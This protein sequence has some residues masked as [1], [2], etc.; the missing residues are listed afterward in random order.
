MF[1]GKNEK[2]LSYVKNIPQYL[3][4]IA[5][6][7]FVAGVFYYTVAL[8][9]SFVNTDIFDTLI[10]AKASY[11]SG[12]IISP[13][14]SYSAFL[15]F[16]GSLIMLP[17]IP[18]FGVSFTTHVIGMVIFE[19][20]FF[21]CFVLFFKR[22]GF[23]AKWIMFALIADCSLWL[24][25]DKFREMFMEH[26]IYYSLSAL[27]ILAGY[28]LI[29]SLIKSFESENRKKSILLCVATFLFFMLV[30]TDGFQIVGLSTV[31]IIAAFICERFFDLKTKVFAKENR[32]VIAAVIIVAIATM[33]GIIVLKILLNGNVSE[34]ANNFSV[35]DTNDHIYMYPIKIKNY[36]DCWYQLFEVFFISGISIS[37]MAQIPV[38]ITAAFATVILITVPV[39]AL[40]YRRID[41][42][43][44]KQLFWIALFML[45]ISMTLW[46][47]GTISGTEWRLIPAV[48]CS[49]ILLLADLNYMFE[50]TQTKRF[51]VIIISL[52]I[53][54][55]IPGINY[56]LA[57]APANDTGYTALIEKAENYGIT[58]GYGN[59]WIAGTVNV[60]T[61]EEVDMAFVAYGN[62]EQLHIY[63]YQQ[64]P[65]IH[66][67]NTE[68][69][70]CVLVLNTS[71]AEI[72]ENTAAYESNRNH[73][74]E[75]YEMG[76]E[77]DYIAYFFDKDIYGSIIVTD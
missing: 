19:I 37:D 46:V 43:S 55:M 69:S 59:Y 8:S 16:G 75:K 77:N 66:E 29:D 74:I 27:F 47:L 5:T 53:L 62:D 67:N 34:Y 1:N 12:K 57:Y 2:I 63:N 76:G 22:I 15:P 70:K 71:E 6:L 30:A 40:L 54:S 10:W 36:I 24:C 73:I 28:L 65:Y 21:V 64:F 33:T 13:D 60:L 50:R 51:S 39:T 38:L 31:P 14:F 42:K 26:I 49:F 68:N 35:Y 9:K 72:F 18:V 11:E 20:I 7:S 44:V 56:L 3:L 61:K 32:H 45:F 41:S 25:S 23:N 48:F 52:M 17:F 58:D 4:V